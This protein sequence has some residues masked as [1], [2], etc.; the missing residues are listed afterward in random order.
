MLPPAASTKCSASESMRANRQ[1]AGDSSCSVTSEKGTIDEERA[2]RRHCRQEQVHCLTSDGRTLSA[3][4]LSGDA[5]TVAAMRRAGSTAYSALTLRTLRTYQ[6]E[7]QAQGAE[8][9]ERQ[10]ILFKFKATDCQGSKRLPSLPLL[11][12]D[13]RSAN[14]SSAR[15]SR[16][17]SVLG[18]AASMREGEAWQGRGEGGACLRAW[19]RTG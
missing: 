15:L 5:T 8:S 12:S 11:T 2:G 19:Q 17:P 18:Q 14:W 16:G 4:H 1:I 9:L 10:N 7:R 13:C 3:R 6:A